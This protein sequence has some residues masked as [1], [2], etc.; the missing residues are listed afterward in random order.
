MELMWYLV[1][2]QEEKHVFI[3]C[4]FSWL[5]QS[6]TMDLVKIEEVNLY[7]KSF[8]IW[9]SIFLSIFSIHLS[10]YLF[11]YPSSF[12]FRTYPTITLDSPLMLV[13][14]GL[15]VNLVLFRR[16][17]I[18]TK[19]LELVLLCCLSGCKLSPDPGSVVLHQW[20]Y[21]GALA[22]CLRSGCTV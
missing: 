11:F 5:N 8:C 15:Y 14:P 22:V 19:L 20:L 17:L 1:W 4:L 3:F 16:F 12:I 18:R 7:L 2:T 9:I 13:T 21:T 10:I 6:L